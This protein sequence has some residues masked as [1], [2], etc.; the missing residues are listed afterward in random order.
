PLQ[1]V[2]AEQTHFF[3]WQ[4][5]SA[6][7]ETPH[8]P[9]FCRSTS[10]LTHWPPHSAVPGA[11]AHLP[12]WHVRPAPQTTPHAPP[13]GRPV[14]R[15]PPTPRQ[16][17]PELGQGAA[18]RTTTVVLLTTMAS[19]LPSPVTSAKAAPRSARYWPRVQSSFPENAVPV[20]GLTTT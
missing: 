13:F 9:Q 15:L 7:Q 3:V 8:V 5:R 4:V 1:S 14:V 16:M 18:R 10:R 11:Q 2:P 20:D 6:A 19:A 17:L 12:A